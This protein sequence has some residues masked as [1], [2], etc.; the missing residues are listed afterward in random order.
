MLGQSKFEGLT[1]FRD[2]NQ[3]GV[4]TVLVTNCPVD[5]AYK[6]FTY[7]KLRDM[8]SVI[9]DQW[10]D[11]IQSLEVLGLKRDCQIYIGSV[12]LLSRIRARGFL[13]QGNQICLTG[14]TTHKYFRFF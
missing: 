7:V 5:D 12:R 6:G 2:V 1:I 11:A 10:E 14:R 3:E 13:G 9:R 8:A 4:G